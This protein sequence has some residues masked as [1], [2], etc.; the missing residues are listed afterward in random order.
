MVIVVIYGIPEDID[1]KKLALFSGDIRK[2]FATKSKGVT[3]FFPP[4]RLKEGLGEEIAVF[5]YGFY[6]EPEKVDKTVQ[7]RSELTQVVKR[8]FPK[9]E[10]YSECFSQVFDPKLGYVRHV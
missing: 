1:Q 3:I 7:L 9:T 8:H 2:S 6:V 5:V 10:I 4:D